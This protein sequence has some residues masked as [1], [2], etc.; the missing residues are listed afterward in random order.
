MNH[1]KP[2]LDETWSN[3]SFIFFSILLTFFFMSKLSRST[4]QI[5]QS[6]SQVF[7]HDNNSWTKLWNFLQLWLFLLL[8]WLVQQY[9]NSNFNNAYIFIENKTSQKTYNVTMCLY[10]WLEVYNKFSFSE[11]VWRKELLK[12]IHH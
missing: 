6:S 10:A 3:Y 8:R 9:T 12:W 1:Y 11:T 4:S 2:T 5:K 7:R